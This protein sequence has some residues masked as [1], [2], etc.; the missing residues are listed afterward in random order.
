[1]KTILVSFVLVIAACHLPN[2]FNCPDGAICAT[3]PDGGCDPQQWQTSCGPGLVC[4]SDGVCGLQCGN[5]D[6]VCDP[7][8]FCED[9]NCLPIAPSTVTLMLLPG[10]I[11]HDPGPYVNRP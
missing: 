2:T 3:T 11:V 7:G 1:M 9:G 6:V 8:T 4:T 5:G 10:E